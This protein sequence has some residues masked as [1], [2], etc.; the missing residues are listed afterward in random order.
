MKITVVGV[1]ILI[2]GIVLL[3]IVLN[4]V[5]N[6][7]DKSKQMQRKESEQERVGSDDQLNGPNN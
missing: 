6:S 3:V 7:L 5:G 2:G 4:H 1:L